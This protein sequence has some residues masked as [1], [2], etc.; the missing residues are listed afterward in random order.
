MSR[1]LP[2]GML[3][4]IELVAGEAV[5][6]DTTLDQMQERVLQLRGARR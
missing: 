5:A 6:A 1:L 3:S 4:R 2:R